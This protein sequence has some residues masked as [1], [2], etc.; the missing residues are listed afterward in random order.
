M[1]MMNIYFYKNDKDYEPIC[2]KNGKVYEYLFKSKDIKFVIDDIV[3]NN[4]KSNDLLD[5]KTT[6]KNFDIVGHMLI[7]IL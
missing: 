7:I 6:I 3:K 5:A 1:I 2:F 4:N